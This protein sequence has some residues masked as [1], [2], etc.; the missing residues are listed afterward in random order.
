MD[1]EVIS[2]IPICT[3]RQDD[4]WA[5]HYEKSGIFSVRSAYRMLVVNKQHNTTYESTT[6]MGDTLECESAIQDQGLSVEIGQ[7]ILVNG[8]CLAAPQ[9]EDSP[10]LCPVWGTRLME[11]CPSGM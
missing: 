7:T 11:T 10:C 5:W 9:H 3:R 6:G 8:G 4:F 2:N 1:S